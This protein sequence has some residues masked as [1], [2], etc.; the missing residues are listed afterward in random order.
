M[1]ALICCASLIVPMPTTSGGPIGPSMVMTMQP[2]FFITSIA[3]RA[4]ATP[5][6]SLPFLVAAEPRMMWRPSHVPARLVNSPSREVDTISVAGCGGFGHFRRKVIC[7]TGISRMRECHA[8]Q[9]P[10]LRAGPELAGM[11]DAFHA[12]AQGVRQNGH[13]GPDQRAPDKGNHRRAGETLE[14][15]AAIYALTHGSPYMRN[16]RAAVSRGLLALHSRIET[17][18]TGA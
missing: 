8:G 3:S 14:H 16:S 4:A 9:D 2:P 18:S 10:A 5:R 11:L 6:L 12:P 15:A 1:G 13:V 17:A 7:I